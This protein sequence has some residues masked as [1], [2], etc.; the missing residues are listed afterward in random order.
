MSRRATST[1]RRDRSN[2]A[3]LAPI[4]TGPFKFV[5]YE[6]GQYVIAERN[7]DYWRPNV[8]YLDRIVWRVI[9]DRAAAAAQIET[10]QMQFS[11]FS[12]SPSRTW[13]GCPRTSASS[14]RP[15]ATKA[16]PSPTPSS[17]TSAA[18]SSPTSACAA[19]S[20][21]RSTCRSSSTTSSAISPSP[22]PGRFPRPRPT[23][24][25][26]PARRSIRTTR[27]RPRPCSTKPATSPAPAAPAFRCACCR[28]PGAR[29]SRCG[30]PSSS[31]RWPKSASRSRSCATT[32]AAF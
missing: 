24:I 10:G 13:P 32:A 9:T 5:K 8:P 20:R 15:R 1:N 26:A 31:S 21:T 6:R 7:P 19:P 16:T 22:G 3:N 28:P 12:G 23:S 25:P 14:S 17:S 18:R 29:T 27:P 30:R 2:P 11:P 4:G